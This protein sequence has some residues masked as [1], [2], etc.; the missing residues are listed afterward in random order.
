MMGIGSDMVWGF[1]LSDK[2][3]CEIEV[4]KVEYMFRLKMEKRKFLWVRRDEG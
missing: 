4:L 1:V 2:A 3:R